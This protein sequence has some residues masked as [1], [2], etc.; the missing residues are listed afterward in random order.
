MLQQPIISK[1]K[2]DNTPSNNNCRLFSDG[3]ERANHVLSKYS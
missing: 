2:I 1:K 3:D